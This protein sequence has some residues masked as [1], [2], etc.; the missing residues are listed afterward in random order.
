MCTDAIYVFP[1]L[2]SKRET[3]PHDK[4]TMC[5]AR[6]ASSDR[7]ESRDLLLRQAE[8]EDV[9]VFSKMGLGFGAIYKVWSLVSKCVSGGL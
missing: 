1:G 8:V 9:N 4:W 6:V 2:L 3:R 5:L 7:A